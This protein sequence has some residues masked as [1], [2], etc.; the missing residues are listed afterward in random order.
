MKRDI[1]V[2]TES[3]KEFFKDSFE[4]QLTKEKY[5]EFK[6]I[7]FRFSNLS[8]SVCPN[9]DGS[10][11][12][13]ISITLNL[14]YDFS[15]Y[16]SINNDN[17]IQLQTQYDNKTFNLI[18]NDKCNNFSYKLNSKYFKIFYNLK[19]LTLRDVLTFIN[20]LGDDEYSCRI[21][22]ICN[23]LGALFNDNKKIERNIIFWGE[24][25]P[26]HSM[27]RNIHTYDNLLRIGKVIVLRKASKMFN[28]KQF[29]EFKKLSFEFPVDFNVDKENNVCNLS[30]YIRDKREHSD[31]D[32]YLCHYELIRELK[33]GPINEKRE[34]SEF[35][36]VFPETK[37]LIGMDMVDLVIKN[38]NLSRN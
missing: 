34:N 38:I 30:I 7:F 32:W 6:K 24:N 22:H 33:K 28:K 12:D 20:F 9:E 29:K 2:L 35:K 16:F 8:Y 1:G 18:D 14:K 31:W 19:Y 4:Y 13:I 23:K 3:V 17:E 37:E 36:E 10:Q 5:K 25:I 26:E 15:I 27:W 21:D 11:F